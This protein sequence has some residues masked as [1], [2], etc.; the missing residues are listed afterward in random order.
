MPMPAFY[1]N[2]SN[3]Y[4]KIIPMIKLHNYLALS[5]DGDVNSKPYL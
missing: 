5:C 1:M 3:E 4:I 2:I